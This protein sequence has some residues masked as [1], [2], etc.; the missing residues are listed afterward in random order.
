PPRPVTLLYHE[1]YPTKSI[2]LQREFQIKQ[3][4]RKEKLALIK[5]ALITGAQE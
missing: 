3:L 4:E 5:N 2:A 1:S